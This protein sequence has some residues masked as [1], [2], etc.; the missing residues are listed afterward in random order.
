MP[1]CGLGIVHSLSGYGKG[2]GQMFAPLGDVL[3]V[4]SVHDKEGQ[5]RGS[6]RGRSEQAPPLFV[7]Q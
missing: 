5:A 4:I 7:S 3:L 6:L 1:V 2:Q